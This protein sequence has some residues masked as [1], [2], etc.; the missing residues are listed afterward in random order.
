VLAVFAGNLVMKP[1]TTLVLH[2]LSFRA[3]LIWNGLL[4]A[5]AIVACVFLTPATPFIV[6][7]MLL[8]VS[9]LTRSLQFTA[10]NTLAF[11]DVSKDRMSGANT[12]FNM[13]QQIAMGMGIALGAVALR[14]AGLF[15]PNAFGTIPLTNFHV[16]FA[17]VGVIALVGILDVLSLAPTAGDNVRRGKTAVDKPAT[18]KTLSA[19][20]N[21]SPSPMVS[22]VR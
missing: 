19:T 17:I 1:L 2:R 3:I 20:R 14:I 11:A 5:T 18:C 15:E 12:L 7:A 16:A 4:N 8:F 6:I 10:L 13:A 21:A 9:G 22:R